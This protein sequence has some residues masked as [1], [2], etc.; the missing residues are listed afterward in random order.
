MDKYD[1]FINI[2][3]ITIKP[4]ITTAVVANT[5][6]IN[7]VSNLFIAE[8]SHCLRTKFFFVLGQQQ[9]DAKKNLEDLPVLHSDY[10]SDLIQLMHF[11]S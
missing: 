9:L 5:R 6:F 3:L 2:V 11:Q 7:G 4:R 10:Q 8:Y 1:Y